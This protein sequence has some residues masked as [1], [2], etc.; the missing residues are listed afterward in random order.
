MKRLETLIVIKVIFTLIFLIH[1]NGGS[2]NA[3][4]FGITNRPRITSISRSASI[5]RPSRVRKPSVRIQ[6]VVK[7]VYT[8]KKTMVKISPTGL[9][10]TTLP[11]ADITLE[12]T[13][14]GKGIKIKEKVYPLEFKNSNYSCFQFS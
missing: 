8:T 5:S 3:Q 7:P 13:G 4:D 11:N 2:T 10:I 1:F 14:P 12:S 9:S 6:V